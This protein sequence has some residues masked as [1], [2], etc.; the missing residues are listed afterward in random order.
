MQSLGI[1][2]LKLRA[3]V[4]ILA[5][6][7][8]DN[9]YHPDKYSGSEGACSYRRGFCDNNTTGCIIGQAL[10]NL[11]GIDDDLKDMDDVG[12]IDQ[13]IGSSLLVNQLFNDIPHKEEREW[14]IVMQKEQDSGH[15]WGQALEVANERLSQCLNTNTQIAKP[16][17]S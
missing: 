8:P 10:V 3:A 17:N 4:E 5:R 6:D 15:T 1:H 2:P 12:P 13:I 11:G 9:I 14:L 7:N 16:V